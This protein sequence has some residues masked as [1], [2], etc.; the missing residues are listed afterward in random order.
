M[1][2]PT[3]PSEDDDRGSLERYSD[4]PLS[5]E[6]REIAAREGWILGIA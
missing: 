4:P 1:S 6:E 5:H 3:E 2:F